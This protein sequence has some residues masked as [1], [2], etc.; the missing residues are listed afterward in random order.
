MRAG[1][2]R[3]GFIHIHQELAMSKKQSKRDNKLYKLPKS[4]P[5]IKPKKMR[6]PLPGQLNLV[7]DNQEFSR[8]K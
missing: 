1:G 6:K 7:A 2:K 4:I 5:S 3:R 8:K